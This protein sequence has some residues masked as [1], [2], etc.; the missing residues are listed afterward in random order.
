MAS[1]TGNNL[2]FS[3]LGSNDDFCWT[4]STTSS[5]GRAVVSEII[6]FDIGDHLTNKVHSTSLSAAT[7]TLI[8]ANPIAGTGREIILENLNYECLSLQIS[9]S[10]TSAL[11]Q[12]NTK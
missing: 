3:F 11:V 4:A 7:S 5:I 10:S 1:T 2:Q 12:L 9:G 8:W 6:W